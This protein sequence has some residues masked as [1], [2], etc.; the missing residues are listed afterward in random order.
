MVNSRVRGLGD[1]CIVARWYI[2]QY[3]LDRTLAIVWYVPRCPSHART[4][5]DSKL[6]IIRFGILR[7]VWKRIGRRN[8]AT[9][10]TNT[11]GFIRNTLNTP[12]AQH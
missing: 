1:V 3:R 9:N 4:H 10:A 8:N 12:T 5:C 2:F 7:S 11:E 6:A